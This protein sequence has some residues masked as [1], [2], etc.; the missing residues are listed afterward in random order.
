MNKSP[1]FE[2]QA[3]VQG[4]SIIGKLTRTGVKMAVRP[5]YLKNGMQK[6][7]VFFVGGVEWNEM[8]ADKTLSC[9]TNA[10]QHYKKHLKILSINPKQVAANRPAVPCII[11]KKFSHLN[12]C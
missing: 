8:D 2:V 1:S 4:C 5:S 10:H 11:H 7:I 6:D 3:E 9:N 12:Q